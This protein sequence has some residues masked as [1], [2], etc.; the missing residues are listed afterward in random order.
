MTDHEVLGQA[1]TNEAEALKR[2][3]AASTAVREADAKLAAL[4][5]ELATAERAERAAAEENRPTAEHTKR[6]RDLQDALRVGTYRKD[7]LQRDAAERQSEYSAA[8]NA[9][10][11]ADKVLAHG[12]LREAADKFDAALD[13]AA[14]AKR[15]YLA[16]LDEYRGYFGGAVRTNR[17]ETL[18]AANV[19]RVLLQ[20]ITCRL[21]ESELFTGKDYLGRPILSAADIRRDL[22]TDM[23]LIR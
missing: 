20:H 22:G 2:L 15:N 23:P 17:T 11:E 13:A 19:S 7:K 5:Q 1:R 12:K 14:E 3:E 9:R 21:L 18:S 6:V 16:A 8:F 10:T 4:R